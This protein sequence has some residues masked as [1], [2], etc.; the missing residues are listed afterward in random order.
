M[1]LQNLHGRK[2]YRIQDSDGMLDSGKH[3]GI[4]KKLVIKDPLEKEA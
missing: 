4:A 2:G 1:S 3:L